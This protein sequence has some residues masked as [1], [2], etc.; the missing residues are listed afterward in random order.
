MK[1]KCG[2]GHKFTI[3]NTLWNKNKSRRWCKT[4]RNIAKKSWRTREQN[5]LKKE[6]PWARHSKI[7]S[8]YGISSEEYDS[9]LLSQ[10]GLCAL[11]K[12]PFEG[13]G[14]D[15]MAPALDH[16]HVTKE[17]REFI[18]QNCNRIIGLAREDP[19]LLSL[20]AEYLERHKERIM[21]QSKDGKKFGSAFVAK[22]RDTEHDKMA[23]DILGGADDAQH[24]EK[25]TPEFEA[26]EQEGAQEG[27]EAPEAIVAKHGKATSTHTTHDHKANKHHVT[28]THESGHVHQSEHGSAGEAHKHALALAGGDQP[29]PEEESSDP[30]AD[31]FQ[32]PKLA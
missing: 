23:K 32:M 13:H 15:N 28:S 19:N 11:C 10:K 21:F 26:G 25:E 17:L 12:K 9:L 22:R 16:N 18:H 14:S 6:K 1:E 29:M 2:R 31:G 3:K 5:W 30:E 27:K 8:R 20:A 4:C 24:E 7:K